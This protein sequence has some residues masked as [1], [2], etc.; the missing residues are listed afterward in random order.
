MANRT[1]AVRLDPL[2]MLL[3]KG[4]VHL[5]LEFCVGPDFFVHGMVAAEDLVGRVFCRPRRRIALCSGSAQPRCQG[6]LM[7]FVPEVIAAIR[8]E[9]SM[10]SRT[11]VSY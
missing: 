10:P 2:R 6:L 11:I 3:L 1:V 9:K 7:G 5:L 8:H 4:I